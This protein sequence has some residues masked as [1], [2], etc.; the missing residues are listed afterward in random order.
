MNTFVAE[1]VGTML[2]VLLGDGVVAAVLLGKS[3]AENS[4]WIVITTGFGFA[5]AFGVYASAGVSGGHLNPAV[6]LGMAVIHK[7]HWQ[8]VPTYIGG[9]LLGAFIGA[10]LVWIAYLPHW[11]ETPDPAKS[12]RYFQPRPRSAASRRTCC[13]KRSGLSFWFLASW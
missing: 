2:L 5:V 3:K 13:R 8:E 12:S 1:L 6:T 11:R 7:I 10:I 4:G 9:Q